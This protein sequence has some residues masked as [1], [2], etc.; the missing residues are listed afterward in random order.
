MSIKQ[1]LPAL[2]LLG[3]SS[4]WSGCAGPSEAK[5][6]ELK[7]IEF[8]MNE[9]ATVGVNSVQAEIA[10]DLNKWAEENK[11]VAADIRKVELQSVEIINE[12]KN[13]N[14]FESLSLQFAGGAGGMVEA[15]VANTVPKDVATIKPN[16]TQQND[17]TPF[18]AKASKLT[19]VIDAN[20]TEDDSTAHT[21]KA[22]LSF[23]VEAGKQETKK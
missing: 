22:N 1:L 5:P 8:K 19:L 10:I 12:G 20:A 2:T 23:K 9:P 6:Y 7:N 16:L 17:V 21:F 14:N 3:L 15:A 11:L 18:F 4:L 13:F